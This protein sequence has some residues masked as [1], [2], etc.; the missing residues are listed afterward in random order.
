M[1]SVKETPLS[2]QAQLEKKFHIKV[3]IIV[4]PVPA[5]LTEQ[6][7]IQ[8]PKAKLVYGNGK[9]FVDPPNGKP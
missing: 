3:I 7:M 6:Y 1:L 8:N 2:G 5:C 9:P 4:H